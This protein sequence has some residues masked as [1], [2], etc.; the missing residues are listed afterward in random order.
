MQFKQFRQVSDIPKNY[1]KTH[2]K[3]HGIVKNV[4]K[5]GVLFVE[6]TPLIN[7]KWM[8]KSSKPRVNLSS[9]LGQT[10]AMA[11]KYHYWIVSAC[12]FFSDAEFLPV[13]IAGSDLT[14][15]AIDWVSNRLAGRAVWFRLLQDCGDNQ[16][17][18][19]VTTKRV[20]YYLTDVKKESLTI[21][22]F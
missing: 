15:P 3:L 17:A 13:V 11:S 1:I 10:L 21:L 20:H 18:C 2:A 6:H 19:V 8:R 4:D 16:V 5:K 22:L 12:L 9:N 7:I 14:A